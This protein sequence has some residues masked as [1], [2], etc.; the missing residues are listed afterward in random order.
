MNKQVLTMNEVS[1]YNTL[2]ALN[3]TNAYIQAAD[4]V[5][6]TG[7]P[8]AQ[9]MNTLEALASKGKV[10]A[11]PEDIGGILVHTFTPVLKGGHA[12]GFPMDFFE[13]YKDWMLNAL[14]V[15]HAA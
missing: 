4:V 12:Y 7:Q 5:A 3:W 11:G 10:L 14:E 1:L 2:L 8:L 9:L 6:V 15:P 13:S